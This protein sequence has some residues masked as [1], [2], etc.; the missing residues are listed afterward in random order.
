MDGAQA[1]VDAIA[2]PDVKQSAQEYVDEN[3]H[4]AT[5]R[6]DIAQV[7][8]W[9]SRYRVQV[10]ANEFGAFGP[11]EGSRDRY[12]RD[13]RMALESNGIAWSVWSASDVYTKGWSPRQAHPRR[14]HD[15]RARQTDLERAASARSEAG[16][17][18]GASRRWAG[19][20][21]C[22]RRRSA[23]PGAA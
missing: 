23:A 17:A 19:L 3:W 5:I 4:A 7:A 10:F 11:E 12:I 6:A 21:A 16:A 22:R 15:E 13:V 1:A 2:D 20:P 14:E 9:R 18:L 8:E